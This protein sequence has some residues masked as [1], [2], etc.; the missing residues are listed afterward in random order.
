MYLLIGIIIG[1]GLVQATHFQRLRMITKKA[2]TGKPT[3]IFTKKY[4]I[5]EVK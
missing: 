4:Y 3:Q 2:D 5:T 1:I